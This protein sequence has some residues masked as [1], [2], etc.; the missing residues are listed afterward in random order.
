MRTHVLMI[1]DASGSMTPYIDDTIG[2]YNR[3]IDDLIADKEKDYRVTTVLFSNNERYKVLFSNKIPNEF[4]KL[5]TD[6][7]RTA[8]TTA[9]LDATGRAVTDFRD[10]VE[11][12]VEDL[13]LVY[14]TTDG[15]ENASSEW[16]T[17]GIKD[18]IRSLESTGRW[19]FSFL[20]QGVENW[21]NSARMMG[22]S[23]D[24]YVGTRHVGG[25]ST[26]A[27]YNTVS[28]NIRKRSRGEQSSFEDDA[29][30]SFAPD[31]L[32]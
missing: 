22:Y 32:Q 3:I 26:Q 23:R 10:S 15:H 4:V 18:M 25:Q 24:S 8:G 2:G 28:E 13:V 31:E 30:R 14:T 20:S 9:L 29:K 7:Y 27:S 12:G 19:K 17:E 1:V 6:D 21:D 16:T 5:T 11:L